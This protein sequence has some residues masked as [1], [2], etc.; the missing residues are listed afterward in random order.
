MENQKN[1]QGMME[2]LHESTTAYHAVM[3]IKKRLIANRFCEVSE[4]QDLHTLVPGNYF[5]TRQDT[6]IIA[7][8]K[9]NNN[10]KSDGLRIVGTHTDSPA[11]KLKANPD[12]K[13][14]PYWQVG[15]EI[16]GGIILSSWFDRELSLAGKVSLLNQQGELQSVL[17]DL[18]KSIAQIP[19]VAIHLQ[20]DVNENRTINK[21]KEMP[22]ILGLTASSESSLLKV[23]KNHIE[24]HYQIAVEKILGHDLFFYSN[25]KPALI[26]IE[27]EFLTASRLDNLIS[28]WV[29]VQALIEHTQKQQDGI[30]SYP[31]VL[32]C[33]DHE[34]VGSSS[35]VG[36]E[37]NFLKSIIERVWG[38]GEESYKLL[39]K[40]LLISVDNAQAAHPNYLE[41]Y[42]PQHLPII[43][44]GPAIKINAG[45]RYSTSAETTALFTH[46]STKAKARTQ[47]FVSRSDKACGST[48]GPITTTLLG[49]AAID[50]GIPSLAMHSIREFV[51]VRD[52]IDL[53]QILT[54]FFEEK[55]V[56]ISSPTISL[57]VA[58]N[59]SSSTT[60]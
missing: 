10:N 50:V 49:V 27:E 37:G 51:G 60:T 14:T 3:A 28:C 56:R 1:A 9:P 24:K 43:N 58:Y 23:V 53:K 38:G 30:G 15:V 44:G 2:F 19:S 25:E 36:A 33:Y 5:I 34:E 48:I 59:P 8:T 22:P 35:A 42:D 45:Q 54:I 29:G 39:D 32:A 12:L 11:L 6:A 7:F 17:I 41:N 52:V 26:G 57:D 13:S 55:N 47:T 21:Q 46:W 40:S 20:R 4:Q 18:K 16:Y 31:C